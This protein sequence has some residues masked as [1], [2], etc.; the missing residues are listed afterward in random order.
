MSA[1]ELAQALAH[2]GIKLPTGWTASRTYRVR[3]PRCNR[4][5]AQ[6]DDALSVTIKAVD[7]V[8]WQCFRCEWASGWRPDSA[9]PEQP[10][11][12]VHRQDLAKPKRAPG[13]SD[14]W[15]RFWDRGAEITRDCT[16]GHYFEGRLC[17]LPPDPGAVRWHPQCWHPHER[18]SFPAIVALVTDIYTCKPISL[19]FT[20]LAEDGSGKAPIERPRLYLKDHPKKGGVVRLDPDDEVTMGVIV[21]EGIETG[22]SYRLEYAPVWACLDA[23]NL[24]EFP[25]LP[26]LEGLTVLVDNDKAGEDAFAEV[27]DRY[28]VAGIEVIGIR[29]AAGNDIN[30]LARAS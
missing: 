19:H 18:R 29:S 16:A 7:D 6:R 17:A 2:A 23:G 27:R 21:C 22:L 3:C 4:P 26:G 13:L 10:I 8:V 11:K 28:E 5:E 12:A 30:D 20:F 1:A 24:G 14:Y 25:V 9:V 15:G